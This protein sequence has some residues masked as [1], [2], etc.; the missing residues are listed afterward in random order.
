M[1]ALTKD[2]LKELKNKHTKVE[3]KEDF[4]GN[5]YSYLTDT[6]YIA[7]NFEEQKVPAKAKT[8]NKKA[9]RL[10][11]VCHECIH[12][13]QSKCMHILNTLFSNL[14]ILLAIISIVVGVFWT[15]PAWLKIVTCL[16]ILTSI[17]IRLILETH[18]VNGSIKL[19]M[20]IVS[21]NMVEDIS[22]KDIQQGAE[23]M[24]KHKYLALLQMVIDKI[25]FLILVLVI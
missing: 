1:E 18:A 16:V 17:I 9:A 3:S 7:K 5:Y 23:Y 2:I 14:S 22:K 4:K 25:I 24:N 8:I 10:V 12:S 6:I 11:V 19:A 20:D 15:S 21:K 13:V